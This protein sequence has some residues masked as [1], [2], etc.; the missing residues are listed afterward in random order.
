[1]SKSIDKLPIPKGMPEWQWTDL[2]V[3]LMLLQ[4]GYKQAISVHIRS[5]ILEA[6]ESLE[7]LGEEL[8]AMGL[9]CQ[10]QPQPIHSNYHL[11]VGK[12]N[13]SVAALAK[14][15]S[16]SLPLR[17][18][19]YSRSSIRLSGYSHTGLYKQRHHRPY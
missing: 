2:R 17:D 10:L 14:A 4:A 19:P 13:A 11:Y 3:Q 15:L 8:S 9:S 1:M 7:Q 6:V 12:D 16:G 5:D 18:R